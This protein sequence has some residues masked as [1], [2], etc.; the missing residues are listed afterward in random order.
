MEEIKDNTNTWKDKNERTNKK[1][2]KLYQAK[3]SSEQQRKM[4]TK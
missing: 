1:Q 4:S 3:K 2:V